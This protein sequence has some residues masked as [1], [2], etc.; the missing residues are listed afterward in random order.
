MSARSS[1]ARTLLTLC[2]ASCATGK[3]MEDGGP[4]APQRDGEAGTQPDAAAPD[5]GVAIPSPLPACTDAVGSCPSRSFAVWQVLLD[6]SEFGGSARFLATG[7]QAVLVAQGD[8]TY[9]VARIRGPSAREDEAPYSSRIFEAAGLEPIAVAEARF[10]SPV[11]TTLVL[12]CRQGAEC[13]LWRAAENDAAFMPWTQ[14]ELPAGFV[15]R[16]LVID[17]AEFPAPPIA[18][19]FGNGL[20]CFKDG[21]VE[22]IAVSGDVELNDVAIG[23]NWSLAVGNGGRWFRRERHASGALG[24]WHEQPLLGT[25]DLAQ[26]SVRGSAG[27]TIIGEGK[28]VAALGDHRETF[29]CGPRNDLVA[30]LLDPGLPTLAYAVAATGEI[31]QHQEPGP[32]LIEPYCAYQQLPPLGPVLDT[33]IAPCQDAMNPRVLTETALYGINV[34]LLLDG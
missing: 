17:D 31:F 3:A 24:A 5:S 34:C 25:G 14:S 11:E 16:G 2:I 33:S 27:G 18:C 32:N 30:F 22:A 10:E 6:A 23:T 4:T 8:T 7:G 12:A 15:P 29:A 26:A 28:L 13:A 9:S 21:W 1:C 19:V 20:L